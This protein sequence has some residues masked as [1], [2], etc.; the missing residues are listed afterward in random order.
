VG[1]LLLFPVVFGEIDA[2]AFYGEIYP[3]RSS[4][5]LKIKPFSLAASFP[6]KV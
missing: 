4:Q 3:R 2:P 1:L 5:T 6:L